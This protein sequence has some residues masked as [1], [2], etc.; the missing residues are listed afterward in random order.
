MPDPDENGKPSTGTDGDQESQVTED[1][2]KVTAPPGDKKPEDE[3]PEWARKAL[4]DVRA[5]AAN[6][7]TKLREAEKR[8]SEA[9]SPE[10][11]E[12]A[13]KEL[14]ESNAKLER[15]ILVRDVAG[16]H[17]LPASLAAR[18]QGST[19]EELEA[20]AK[21]LAKLLAP[22]APPAGTPRGGLDPSD[23]DDGEMDPRKLARM[24]RR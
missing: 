7:R 20:D 11:H 5:E 23:N 17:S 24:T 19:P 12:A 2:D 16:K 21:E 10:D 13:L 14:R 4:T 6:Y 9:K 18:L 22:P 1:K 3:L 8:V 15:D